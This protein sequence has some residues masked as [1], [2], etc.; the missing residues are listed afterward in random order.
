MITSNKNTINWRDTFLSVLL[1]LIVILLYQF[2]SYQRHLINPCDKLLPTIGQIADAFNRST[3]V[4]DRLG[5]YRLWEDSVAS[6]KRIYISLIFIF[7]G[8]LFGVFMGSFKVLDKLFYK[9]FLF[10]DKIPALAI[11]PILFIV[12]GLGEV[13]KIALIVIGVV[14]TIVLDIYFKVKAF[15]EEQ[16]VKAMTMSASKTQT[17]FKIILPKIFPMALESIR[18]NFK[19][20]VLFLIS[21]EALA[22]TEGL[23]YRIFVVRRYMAMDNI[24]SYVIWIGLLSLLVDTAICF[25][26]KKSYTWYNK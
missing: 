13:S 25:W 14:P 5:T 26:L 12:F 22:A 1:F 19:A 23:G 11:L 20:I 8:V 21:G 7:F 2:F 4:P 9:F 16:L 10:F 24:I 15:P 6:G 17:I 3:F 18:L